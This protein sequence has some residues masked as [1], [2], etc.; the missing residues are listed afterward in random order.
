MRYLSFNVD[1][2]KLLF[3]SLWLPLATLFSQDMINRQDVWADVDGIVHVRWTTVEPSKSII[4]FG[5]DKSLPQS[6]PED[7]SCLR[8][9]T[10]NR[11]ASGTG[12]ANNHRVD[13][14][15]TAWPVFLQ[16]SGSTEKGA[17][18]AS[19]V[20][21]VE[22][23]KQA[24]GSV[25]RVQI[26]LALDVGDWQAEFAPY[27]GG[28]PFAQGLLGDEDQVQLL[29]DGQEVPLQTE[30]VTRWRKDQSI[31]WLRIDF[32]ARKGAK[33]A[34]L[35]FGREIRRKPALVTATTPTPN[36]W[37]QAIHLRD[38]EGKSYA[39]QSTGH[40]NVDGS[41]KHTS[42]WSGKFFAADGSQLWCAQVQADTWEGVNA[43]R[44]LVTVENDHVETEMTAIRDLTLNVPGISAESINLGV[45]AEQVLL[46]NGTRV[47]Q[48]EDFEWVHQPSGKKG[49]RMTGVART[50]NGAVFAFPDFWEQWPISA[51][52]KE[53]KLV[54][55]LCPELPP[56]FYE[57]RVD[58]IKLYFNIRDGVHTF[59]QGWAKTWEFWSGSE[60]ASSFLGAKPVVSAPPQW[61]EDSFALRDLAV[62]KRGEFPSYDEALKNNIDGFAASRDRRREYGMMNFGDWYGERVTNWGNL[63][64]DLGH[65]FL[66]QFGRTGYAPFFRHSTAIIR[67][68]RDVDTRHHASDP[69][70]IGQQWTHCV[71][72]TAGYYGDD[73]QDPKL[74]ARH[75]WDDKGEGSRYMKTYA[76]QGWSDNRGHIWSQGMLAHYLF[77]GERRSWE[78]GLLISDWAAG[79]QCTNFI[80]G[81]AREPGWMSKLVMGAYFCTEDTFHLHAAAIMLDLTHE[82]SVATGDH[83]FY[84]HKLSRGHCNCPP[85]EQ[86]FGE[87]GFMLGVL[88]TGMKMYYDV[89][90]DP[91]IAEDI[92]K[93]A[94]FIAE[95]MWLPNKTGFRYTSCPHSPSGS[96]S[97]WIMLEG[98]AFAARHN[99][100]SKLADLCR[101]A[102]TAAWNSLPR[103]GKSAGYVLC[104]SAQALEQVARLPGIGFHAFQQEMAEKLSSPARRDLPTLL[105]NPDFEQDIEGWPSRGWITE[106]CKDVKHSGNAS[107]K[108]SGSNEGRNEYINTHYDSPFSPYEII[109]LVPGTAYELSAWLRV[110]AI[111]LG[112]DA[113]SIRIATRDANGTRGF[114]T[115][116]CYDLKK[117]GTWQKLDVSFTLPAW[118]TRNYIALI[119]N[120]KGLIET[121]MYLDDLR[122]S[123]KAIKSVVDVPIHLRVEVADASCSGGAVSAPNI[124]FKNEL[125]ISGP[126]G[127]D[128]RLE[129]PAA[130]SYY[131]WIRA[132]NGA[133]FTT[134][135]INDT[136][137]KTNFVA[138]K[139]NW[140]CLGAVSVKAGKASIALRGI[141]PG[142][143]F[144]R[145]VLTSEPAG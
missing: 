142:K 85:E 50:A 49:K 78:V 59:R 57:N 43:T 76:Q 84:F 10:N 133:E 21:R 144:G 30:V 100:N 69:R 92:S 98:L 83:G 109:W 111:T 67:H 113:P 128:W 123:P 116:D 88:M 38:K 62:A 140:H 77:G 24:V 63:E 104:S 9:T 127:A 11:N 81:N 26:P 103:E 118:N 143:A 102:L 2:K 17:K 112:N 12:W 22:A 47:F 121:T 93:I 25:A 96:S 120:S 136:T 37:N 29:V 13:F 7:S 64:Y 137:I 115:T 3:V 71:G 89:T 66:T 54:V 90:G 129:I 27:C 73:H 106:H 31:K 79:P 34:V 82:K 40:E 99:K 72:H 122:L 114:F 110:D 105:P 60:D 5:H 65:A 6:V 74:Y 75:R 70:R 39:F 139:V 15:A 45:G 124:Y 107:L 108:I 46:Q 135:K 36:A 44:Y 131:I 126:G 1:L 95:T 56:K 68:Q 19:G 61:I 33:S 23:P 141:V 119:T 32:L 8:G 134:F 53:G 42:R 28:V 18:F 48:R 80:F 132:E 130:V 4:A 35:E 145:I 101:M 87:A 125:G 91:K 86:H 16:I 55:G 41:C 51:E 94:H 20:L 97:A 52:V 117:L 138:D 14:A 58:E